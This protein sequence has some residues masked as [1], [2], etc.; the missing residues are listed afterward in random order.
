MSSNAS[1]HDLEGNISKLSSNVLLNNRL[2]D[3]ID[4]LL[5]RANDLTAFY[6]NALRV[7]NDVITFNN[8][9]PG[10]STNKQNEVLRVLNLIAKKLLSIHDRFNGPN[11][12]AI[13]NTSHADAINNF[14]TNTIIQT[15]LSKRA[16][17]S[18]QSRSPSRPSVGSPKRRLRS[19]EGVASPLSS[20]P[21]VSPANVIVNH[22]SPNEQLGCFGKMC[23]R[24]S[25]NI[26]HPGSIHP[27]SNVGG[28]RK[29][30]LRTRRTRRSRGRRSR[31]N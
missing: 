24:F 20:P 12:N 1:K 8:Y 10:N 19:A 27:G 15:L 4:G 26:V 29:L 9:N 16:Q 5:T 22:D 30:R 18:A 3:D 17:Q 21:V 7:G 23:R 28:K 13:M 6:R 25:R 2:P 31:L 11:R 14:I